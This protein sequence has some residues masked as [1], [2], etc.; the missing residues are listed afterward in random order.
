MY[1]TYSNQKQKTERPVSAFLCAAVIRT[2]LPLPY[3]HCNQTRALSSL[4]LLSFS[5]SVA[6]QSQVV[7]VGGDVFRIVLN[8]DFFCAP[9]LPESKAKV[10]ITFR[11]LG[12]GVVYPCSVD[13]FEQVRDSPPD[14]Y[15]DAEC[16]EHGEG[17]S[18]ET[19]IK[20]VFQLD[21]K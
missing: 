10:P 4:L 19:L 21:K 20:I 8:P 14:R 13:P 3:L 6:A 9:F 1:S 5:S 2:P 12:S 11:L 7:V 18:S 17:Q 16:A 15:N